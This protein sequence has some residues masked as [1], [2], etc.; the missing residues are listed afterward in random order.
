MR[1][2]ARE[3]GDIGRM[4]SR[5]SQLADFAGNAEPAKV[6]HCA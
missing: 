5:Q 6:L 3:I 1:A 2:E 4:I